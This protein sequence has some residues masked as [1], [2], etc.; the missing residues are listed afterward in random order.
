MAHQTWSARYHAKIGKT[1]AELIR[2]GIQQQQNRQREHEELAAYALANGWQ[3]NESGT[4][5]Q[6]W[7]DQLKAEVFKIPDRASFQA[8]VWPDGSH[9]EHR[10]FSSAMFAMRWAEINLRVDAAMAGDVHE[11]EGP[12][13]P[14]QQ[15]SEY[16]G[17]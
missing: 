8:V 2:E 12:M 15:E 10:A 4:W 6:Y 14:Q 5:S 11:S 7:A 9:A 1:Q 3:Q 13:N 16:R 17:L